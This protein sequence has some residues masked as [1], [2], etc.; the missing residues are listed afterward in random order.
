MANKNYTPNSLFRGLDPLSDARV[1]IDTGRIKITN[2][3]IKK[4][5]EASDLSKSLIS[6]MD[7]G[8]AG[9]EKA[10]GDMRPGHKYKKQKTRR[11][12]Y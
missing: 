11:E 5:Q 1:A 12:R 2:R 9:L 7:A 4:N 3:T 6:D 10:L 8:I